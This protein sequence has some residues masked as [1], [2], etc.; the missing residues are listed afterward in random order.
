MPC[1]G[2]GAGSAGNLYWY[3]YLAPCTG[4]GRAGISLVGGVHQWEGREMILLAKEIQLRRAV[5][6]CMVPPMV[7]FCIVRRA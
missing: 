5:H 3:K 4:T 2:A 1:T 6:R 7:S